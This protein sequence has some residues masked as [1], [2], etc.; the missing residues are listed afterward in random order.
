MGG[1]AD[2]A[3][4]LAEDTG[5]GGT[6]EADDH[7]QQYG[8]GLVAGQPCDQFQGAL[9]G[10]ALQRLVVGAVVPGSSSRSFSSPVA[11]GRTFCLR[12]WSSARCRAMVAVQPRNPAPSPLN[13][14]RSRA[15]SSQASDATSSASSPTIPRT[16]PSSPG[17]TIRYA[18]AKA[19]SSPCCVRATAAPSSPSYACTRRGSPPWPNAVLVRPESVRMRTVRHGRPCQRPRGHLRRAPQKR[20][21][22]SG[23]PGVPRNTSWLR[24]P[25]PPVR[26]AA[27]TAP[28]GP[29]SGPRS[30]RS[31]R[32]ARPATALPS[33]TRWPR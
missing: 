10:E 2:R 1:G 17:C 13:R 27:P 14:P 7:P 8:L 33:P 11:R 29:A 16:Y 6:V 30:P 26:A 5:G 9:R 24:R 25:S 31:R 22:P 15:I 18:S 20:H 28:A 19:A 23:A 3:R 32:S 12:R 4:T 21:S